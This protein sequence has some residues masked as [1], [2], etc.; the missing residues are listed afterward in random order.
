M[1]EVPPKRF[2][3]A[4][5]RDNFL[6]ALDT[7]DQAVIDAMAP[8]LVGCENLLPSSTCLV[9]GLLPGSTY[10]DGINALQSEAR[11]KPKI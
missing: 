1:R 3:S 4:S 6:A 10:G 11:K 5:V 7:Q 2:A 9:L 8:Y